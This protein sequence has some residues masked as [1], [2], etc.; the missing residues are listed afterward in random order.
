[1]TLNDILQVY[2]G[3]HLV[4]MPDSDYAIFEQRAVGITITPANAFVI[5]V[6]A[7]LLRAHGGMHAYG[8]ERVAAFIA[9]TGGPAKVVA[10][11]Y[12]SALYRE[13][14]IAFDPDTF[15]SYVGRCVN[16][17]RQA[18]EEAEAEG[19]PKSAQYAHKNAVDYMLLAAACTGQGIT[20]VPREVLRPDA[21]LWREDQASGNSEARLLMSLACSRPHSWWAKELELLDDLTGEES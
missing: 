21:V 13:C 2:A 11:A 12:E 19:T 8:D 10:E 1:M 20:Y 3:T 5:F 18:A 4:L 9:A 15:R 14:V 17:Y 16:G 6:E 7:G